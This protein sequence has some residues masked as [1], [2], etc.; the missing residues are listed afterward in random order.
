MRLQT[1]VTALFSG[2][3]LCCCYSFL[4]D[5]ENETFCFGA[6]VGVAV[7]VAVD[8]KTEPQTKGVITQKRLF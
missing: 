7:G 8:G 4:T 5:H 3:F 2:L 6:A 1:Y